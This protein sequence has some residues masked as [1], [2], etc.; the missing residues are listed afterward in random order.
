MLEDKK[1]AEEIVEATISSKQCA[2]ISL[3]MYREWERAMQ[4][5][6]FAMKSFPDWLDLIIKSAK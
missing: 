6:V 2:E 1:D 3:Y 4:P 5:P